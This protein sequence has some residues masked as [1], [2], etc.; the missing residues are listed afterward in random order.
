VI[1]SYTPTLSAL[2]TAREEW[3]SPEMK[4]LRAL[5]IAEASPPGVRQ[6]PY[7]MDEAKAVVDAFVKSSC[8]VET[9]GFDVVQGSGVDLALEQLNDA[10]L[11]HFACHGN[12]HLGDPLESGF[13]LRDKALTV[14]MLMKLRLPNAYFAFL[15]ACETAKGDKNQPDQLIHLAA[16]VLHA[17]FKS[18]VATMW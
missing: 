1:S 14:A 13:R 7:A 4:D 6:I 17:G 15:S 3:K 16:A 18:I 2:I 8:N 12:Q 10:N 11:V 9:Q 5:V